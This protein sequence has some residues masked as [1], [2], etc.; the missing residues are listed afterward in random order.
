MH[1]ITEMLKRKKDVLV[2]T[3]TMQRG[4]YLL[5]LIIHELQDLA[6]SA[7]YRPQSRVLTLMMRNHAAFYL[8]NH[9]DPRTMVQG[10]KRLLY[11]DEGF[12]ARCSRMQSVMWKDLQ[13]YQNT[14]Y[15][16]G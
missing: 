5:G 10:T 7:E 6:L 1:L 15:L 12:D 9:G 3:D 14:R 8:G 13:K 4:D 16:D 11:L 2:V